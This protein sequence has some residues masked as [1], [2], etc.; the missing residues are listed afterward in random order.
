LG[1]VVLQHGNILSEI[2]SGS[3]FLDLG[4]PGLMG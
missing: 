3:S 4:V 1:D 2:I